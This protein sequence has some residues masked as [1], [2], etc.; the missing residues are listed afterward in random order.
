MPRPITAIKSYRQPE[1]DPE[2]AALTA[3]RRV[4]IIAQWDHMV[5][6]D[7]A[8]FKQERA[9]A[10][11]ERYTG[12]SAGGKQGHGFSRTSL[13]RKYKAWVD[14]GRNWRTLDRYRTLYRLPAP[15]PERYNITPASA[16]EYFRRSG[17]S[18]DAWADRNGFACTSV[19]AALRGHRPGPRSKFILEALAAELRNEPQQ[20]RAAVSLLR[21]EWSAF[22]ERLGTLEKQLGIRSIYKEGGGRLRTRRP[23]SANAVTCEFP[24]GAPQ[25]S[26]PPFSRR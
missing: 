23:E 26:G 6:M 14:S 13:L 21:S 11:A 5:E 9:L 12:E 3:K 18:Q 24:P 17:V 19:S 2:Y 4:W 7:S 22:G 1:Q 8:K 10:I 25:D 20:I 15:P 16:K